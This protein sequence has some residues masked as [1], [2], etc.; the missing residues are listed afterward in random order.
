M[1]NKGLHGVIAPCLTPFYK[2]GEVNESALE[3]IIGF[4]MDKVDGIS[5]CAIYGSGILMNTEQRMRVAEIAADVI[6]GS[7]QLSVFVGSTNTDTS[8]LLTKHAEQIGADAVTCVEPIYYKQVDDALFWHYQ[9]LIDA[10]DLPVYLYD[11]PEYAG[12]YVSIELLKRLADYGLKGAITGAA[13][14]G[15]EYIWSIM[16][17]IDNT[18][19]EILSIRDGLALPAM[20][21]GAVGFESGVANF[22]PELTKAFND[23]IVQGNFKE[24]MVLQ[25]RMHQLRDISHGFGRNIPTLH[26]LVNMRGLETGVPKKPFYLLSEDEIDSLWEK[27]NSLNFD[28]PLEIKEY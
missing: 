27:L 1:K 6:R 26:A 17:Q 21:K 22:F 14:Q 4:L 7:C 3:S 23:Q 24:A 15:I 28:I 9:L 18:N 20:M 25:D 12:N 5:I 2:D 8:V 10:S 11:S 19:F 13:I 16:R